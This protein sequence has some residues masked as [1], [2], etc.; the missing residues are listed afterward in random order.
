[1]MKNSIK[2]LLGLA[3]VMVGFQAQALLLTGLSETD[4]NLDPDCYYGPS[5]VPANQPTTA[6]IEALVGVS[7]LFEL[8]K[9]DVGGAETGA[10]SSSYD[11]SF[12]NTELDPEDGLI[13][14]VGGDTI[15]CPECFLLVKDGASDPNWYIFG[16]GNW[17]GTDDIILQDFWVGQG[18]ISNV[19]I[20]G[21]GVNVPEPG[22]LALLA[23]GLFALGLRKKL[24]VQQRTNSN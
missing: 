9:Q 3:L 13:Q 18:A 22:T 21:T 17:N 7:P 1:M 24:K 5:V 15:T 16:I 2:I 20:F 4:C 19:A 12:F 23:L 14:Y 11:T 10:F 8:Y 6:D